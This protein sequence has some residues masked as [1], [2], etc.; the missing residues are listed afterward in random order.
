MHKIGCIASVGE[1]GWCRCCMVGVLARH[2]PLFTVNS[3]TVGN[4]LRGIKKNCQY[5]EK[6]FDVSVDELV[7]EELFLCTNGTA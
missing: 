4:M 5:D 7:R 3:C 1:T 6:N 2:F